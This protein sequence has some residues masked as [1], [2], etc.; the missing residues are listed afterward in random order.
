MKVLQGIYTLKKL[1]LNNNNIT[2]GAADDIATV[3][4][5][6]INLQELNLGSNNLQAS[7]TIRIARELKR[8]SSLTKVYINHNN[9]T[10]EA[11]DDIAVAI[12]C[13]TKLQEFDISGNNLTSVIKIMQSLKVNST[14]R[15][16]YL[17]QLL[18]P[19]IL[20]WKTLT[21]VE[22]ILKQ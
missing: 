15:K 3:I 7:G 10:H 4:S 9:I 1:Y 14:L 11:A 22:T 12:S 5:S 2:Q 20:K 19:V 17:L 13:T 18:S 16:L 6:N 8:I 21:S